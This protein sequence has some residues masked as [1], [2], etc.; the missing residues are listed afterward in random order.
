[1][2][3]NVIEGDKKKALGRCQSNLTASHLNTD[4]QFSCKQIRELRDPVRRFGNG[5]FPS[6]PEL[7]VIKDNM[8]N[9]AP[10]HWSLSLVV[11]I[12]R[13]HLMEP[14]PPPFAMLRRAGW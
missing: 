10:Q 5:V 11:Q 1:M 4:S 13:N 8:L 12:T 14:P 7:H 3:E 9:R 2:G 6:G